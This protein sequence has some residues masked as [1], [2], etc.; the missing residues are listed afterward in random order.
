MTAKT[1]IEDFV[2]SFITFHNVLVN[3]IFKLMFVNPLAL[4]CPEKN[5]S[6]NVV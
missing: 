6:E 2:I 1:Y 4:K 5:A 3:F